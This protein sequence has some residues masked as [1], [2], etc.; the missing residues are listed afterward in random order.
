M[1]RYRVGLPAV[2]FSAAISKPSVLSPVIAARVEWVCHPSVL[3]SFAASAPAFAVSNR[4]S[5]AVFVSRALPS[6]PAALVF[7]GISISL[8]KSGAFCPCYLAKPGG[9]GGERR[10]RRRRNVST[11]PV[12]A[13]VQSEAGRTLANALN[14]E[15][16]GEPAD[17]TAAMGVVAEVSRRRIHIA[18]PCG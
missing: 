17:G 13:D 4:T 1:I 18:K 7:V 9:P 16:G 10:L 15:K 6:G 14:A 11:A 5:C 8:V 12:Q 3:L 2:G